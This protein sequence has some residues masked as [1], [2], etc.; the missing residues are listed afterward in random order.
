MDPL[1]SLGPEVSVCLHRDLWSRQGLPGS[2]SE[3]WRGWSHGGRYFTPLV[4]DAENR[5]EHSKDPTDLFLEVSPDP[6]STLPTYSTSR[7]DSSRRKDP[8]GRGTSPDRGVR[9]VSG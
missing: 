4:R 3:D 7:T 6:R 2:G 9:P 1:S 5:D 8:L